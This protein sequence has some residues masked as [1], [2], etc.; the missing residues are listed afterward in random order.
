MCDL[1]KYLKF[2]LCQGLSGTKW[3]RAISCV[4][5]DNVTIYFSSTSNLQNTGT[6]TIVFGP[7]NFFVR[8]QDRNYYPHF[9]GE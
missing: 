9:I 7:R 3:K 8:E 1:D 5:D 4:V 6:L 2:V